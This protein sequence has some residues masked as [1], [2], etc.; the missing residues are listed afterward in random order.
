[1]G[2]R[3]FRYARRPVVNSSGRAR[4]RLYLGVGLVWLVVSLVGARSG[5]LQR[6]RPPAPQ[7]VLVGLTAALI[8]LTVR[9][10]GRGAWL[11]GPGLTLVPGPSHPRA[12][13][14]ALFLPLAAHCP[15]P[16]RFGGPAR[17]G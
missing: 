16:P 5:R 13:H 3:R 9:V 2:V 7:L 6:L 14:G 10:K 11:A 15:L 17:R 4:P 12:V 8:L 1:M